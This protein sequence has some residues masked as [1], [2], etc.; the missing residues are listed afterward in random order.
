MTLKEREDRFIKKCEKDFGK[1]TFESE[2]LLRYG[3]SQG[4]QELDRA[5]FVEGVGHQKA[6]VLEALGVAPEK[7]L[8]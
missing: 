5:A 8:A 1:M 4:A 3:F 2:Q 6:K 7:E